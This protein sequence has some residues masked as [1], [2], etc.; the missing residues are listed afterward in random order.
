LEHWAYYLFYNWPLT[1]RRRMRRRAQMRASLPA[2]YWHGSPCV[3]AAAAV[4]GLVS[5]AHFR[6]TGQLPSLKEYWWLVIAAPLLCGS[7][8]ALGSGGAALGR[9]IVLA[10][11]C[12]A[13][14]GVVA[15]AL[16]AIITRTGPTPETHLIV[17]QGVWQVFLFT[18]L[19]TVGAVMT[20]LTLP[21]PREVAT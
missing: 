15:T 17:A 19:S 4:L 14:T 3:L 9:R 10:A 1:I 18:I 7:L 11:V 16:L 20:E 2:R 5:Y 21:E 6:R 8:V 13:S 12:G